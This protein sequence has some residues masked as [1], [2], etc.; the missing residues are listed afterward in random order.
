MSKTIGPI[1]AG[2]GIFGIPFVPPVKSELRTTIRVISPKP[3]VTIA[4]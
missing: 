4:K 2:G 1:F 3:K